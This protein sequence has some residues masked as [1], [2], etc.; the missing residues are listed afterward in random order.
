MKAATGITVLLIATVSVLAGDEPDVV[1]V[2]GSFSQYVRPG[3]WGQVTA[4][5]DNPTEQA[6]QVKFILFAKDSARGQIHYTHRVD[7]P[8]RTRRTVRLGHRVAPIKPKRSSSKELLHGNSEQNFRLENTAT[9]KILDSDFIL[10][11][12]LGPKQHCMAY[13]DPEAP[14][15]QDHSYLVKIPDSP[16]GQVA[17][18]S[19]SQRLLPDRWSG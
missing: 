11:R 6:M 3:R 4:R 8:S 14:V 15:G 9:N 18:A 12:P 2:L 1:S 5:L 13:V 10:V 7:L 17:L 16:F 19:S